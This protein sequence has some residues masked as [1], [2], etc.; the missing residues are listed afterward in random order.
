MQ[1]NGTILITGAAGNLGKAVTEKFIKENYNVIGTIVEKDDF[2]SN[3]K[4]FESALVNLTDEKVSADLIESIIKKHT[5]IDVAVLTVGGFAMGKIA[6]TKT[7]DIYKQYKLNFETAYNIAQP[8]FLQMIKQNS[9]RIFLIGSKPGLDA[10]SGKG[11]IAYGLSKSLI[12][13]LAE[14]MNDEAKG[15]NVVVN[16]IV[17]G[18]IDTSQNRKAMP[19]ADFSKWTKAEAIAD[20]IFWHC[21]NEASVLR[22]PV[23]KVYN[24]A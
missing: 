23:I 4:N 19:D 3:D 18:T 10:R 16:V 9:G 6:D 12:F 11:M 2:V 7:S 15:K 22:E 5:S 1:N 17:P 20:I 13:R 8:V 24:N 14:L 21:S